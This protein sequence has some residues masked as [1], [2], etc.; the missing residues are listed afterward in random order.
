MRQV[1]AAAAAR[2]RSV[3]PR[4]ARA[5]LA[6]VSASWWIAGGWA[7]D[8]FLGR[9]TR[10]HQD[11]DV[12]ILRRDVRGVLDAL[13]GWEF[14]EASDGELS[15]PLAGEPRRQVNSLWGRL[16]GTDEWLL[17]LMLD[18]AEG[19]EWVFRRDRGVRRALADA[20]RHNPERIAYLAP[21]IQLLYKAS[22][23]R[24]QDQADFLRVAPHLAHEPRAWLH[25][26]L[27]RSSPRHPW[28][29]ALARPA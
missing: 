28:L 19:A 23:L 4:Q 17:E 9:Q 22:H 7:L 14:F 6:P 24:P 25:D 26:A 15:G 29:P 10:P 16:A 1:Y 21:E 12:G 2:W 3:P 20:I 5:V 18:D 11:L 8:L 27:T 13:S